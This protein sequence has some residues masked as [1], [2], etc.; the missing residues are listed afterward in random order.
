MAKVTVMKIL[1]KCM[2]IKE[3][4]EFSKVGNKLVVMDNYT[5]LKHYS[6]SSNTEKLKKN[7]VH[8]G[9]GFYFTMKNTSNSKRKQTKNMC[10]WNWVYKGKNIN[11]ENWYL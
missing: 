10:Q 6:G 9:F 7:K 2:F 8:N 1:R 3:F 4:W 5:V 11:K